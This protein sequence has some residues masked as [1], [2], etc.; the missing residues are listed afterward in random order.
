MGK[1]RP[2]PAAELPA[3]V[4]EPFE[5]AEGWAAHLA[6]QVEALAPVGGAELVLVERVAAL[7]WRLR[8]LDRWEGRALRLDVDRWQRH[9]V[10]DA[11]ERREQLRRVGRPDLAAAVPRPL[12]PND[13]AAELTYT[14]AQLRAVARAVE[15][16]AAERFTR[17]EATALLYALGLAAGVE[18]DGCR[19]A[20]LPAPFNELEGA[21]AGVAYT[22][23]LGRKWAA[24]LARAG[25]VAGG[26][27]ALLQAAYTR[28]I[29]D[30]G[31][32]HQAARETAEG[33]AEAQRR[34]DRL[35]DGWAD[36]ARYEAHLSGQL[37]QALGQLE[38]L[39]AR[40]QGGPAPLGAVAL[41]APALG[42][43]AL[44]G[45]TR[46]TLP[47]PPSAGELLAGLRDVDRALAQAVDPD[48]PLGLA[49]LL[50]DLPP[51]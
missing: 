8:R 46:R 45:A 5:S 42:R 43:L 27:R 4:V 13:T 15:G 9:R 41:A 35:P 17:D 31:A 48:D 25:K 49:D 14:G 11:A 23:A 38:R 37:A 39:Q 51:E 21:P 32:T 30:H 2:P 22:V 18:L 28:A 26:G 1:K 40:R 29:Q 47:A 36:R 10:E 19:L 12:H 44:P 24:A 34:A 7:L 3:Q 33:L 16:S 20:G 6:A 50:A